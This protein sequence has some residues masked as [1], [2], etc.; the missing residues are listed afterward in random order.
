VLALVRRTLRERA[1]LRGGERVLVAVSGGPD[2]AA[3][4]HVLQRLAGE[5]RLSLEAASVD[6]GLRQDAA[7]DVAVAAAL[8]ARL[9]V[10]FAGLKVRVERRGSLQ[11]AARRARYAALWEHAAACGAE[12]L[13]VGHTQD[14]QAE[15]VVSRLVRGPTVASLGGI[16][17]RRAD[18][19]IRPLI[20]CPRAA[21][22]DHVERFAL[23]HVA[24]PSNRDPRFTRARVRHA[25]LPRLR[26]EDPA[27]SPHL[28]ALADEAR[29]IAAWIAAEVDAAIGAPP[30]VA[31]PVADLARLP[32]PVRRGAV[33]RWLDAVCPGPVKS[34][35][36]RAAGHEPLDGGGQ[37]LIGEGWVV[38]VHRGSLCARREPTQR[39]RSAPEGGSDRS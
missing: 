24:D 36:R 28:A 2:S 3:L 1:L 11:A 38:R 7:E 26:E 18:G 12:L 16:A 30:P 14:D 34:A 10:P 19:V 33:A 22:R 17:P 9:Q 25:L 29:E 5:L 32:A 4:L 31:L 23:P 13:A 15:T 35:H 21:V 6:H 8:A 27:A 39:T 37:V 20:D